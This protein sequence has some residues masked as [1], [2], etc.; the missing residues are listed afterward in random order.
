MISD[1]EIVFAVVLSEFKEVNPE[2]GSSFNQYNKYQN[3]L[4]NDNEGSS[5]CLEF[6]QRFL[7]FENK[8]PNDFKK[9]YQYSVVKFKLKKLKNEPSLSTFKLYMEM[10]HNKILVEEKGDEVVIRDIFVTNEKKKSNKCVVNNIDKRYKEDKS[11]D[12]KT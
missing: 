12:N 6:Y 8:Y 3:T 7:A 1:K 4:K 2:F 9:A 5:E 11:T 10:F